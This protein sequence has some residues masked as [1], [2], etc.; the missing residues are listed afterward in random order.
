MLVETAVTT[1]KDEEMDL[2]EKLQKTMEAVQLI[3][4]F[5]TDLNVSGLEEKVKVLITEETRSE[6]GKLKKD[7]HDAGRSPMSLEKRLTAVFNICWRY[8]NKRDP[9]EN[10]YY[11]KILSSSNEERTKGLNL[12]LKKTGDF[13]EENRATVG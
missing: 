9:L 10:K 8:F 13:L 2:P 11:K 1:L 4:E 7:I 6:A 3:D 5:K 12:V